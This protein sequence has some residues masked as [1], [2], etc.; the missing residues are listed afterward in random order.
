MS[1]EETRSDEELDR[2]DRLPALQGVIIEGDVRDD[3]V[4]LPYAPLAGSAQERL[5]RARA[6]IVARDSAA[7]A[8]AARLAAELAQARA[9]VA[10]S[11]ERV[12][13]ALANER[14]ARAG[15]QAAR[16]AERAALERTREVERAVAD[17]T[18]QLSSLQREHA[19]SVRQLE[20]ELLTWRAR[21]DAA[22]GDL[23]A[24]RQS[25]AAT[26]GRLAGL[27]EE[28]RAARQE[29]E[30]LRAQALSYQEH[31]R[32]RERR[33]SGEVPAPATDRAAEVAERER[34]QQRTHEL[35][36][37][38]R[39]RTEALDRALVVKRADDALRLEQE[40]RI[41][42][43]EAEMT[44][45]RADLAQREAALA[46]ALV[47]RHAEERR[48]AGFAGAAERVRGE[49]GAEIE[50][51]HA[52]LTQVEPETEALRRELRAK[53]A[54]LTTLADEHRSLRT[55]LD[56]LRA[57]DA[58]FPTAGAASRAEM[59]AG[60]A[61]T[62]AA[63]VPELRRIDGGRNEVYP[64]GRRTR[65]GR[66]PGCELH[67]ESSSVSRHHSLVLCSASEVV[68]EDLN[69]TNGVLVNGRRISRQSLGDG[70]VLTI[71]EAQF[72]FSTRPAEARSAA[73]GTPTPGGTDTGSG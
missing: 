47:A 35:E 72:R 64:L 39:A 13:A 59:A 54:E 69:S 66:A 31:L 6:E 14:A 34:L 42:Q 65:I 22:A 30:G 36:G 16:S 62:D 43:L 63:G 17:R 52:R 18:A 37:A 60:G 40:K 1:S 71:G 56:R 68:I 61:M 12:R 10:D 29:A 51:L 41:R 4:P 57:V 8:R 50:R 73:S 32:T 58:V 11:E 27:E 2:T 33:E 20:A 19:A 21:A 48:S 9:A 28:L 5:A 45:S 49:L 46:E 55:T 70:D 25:A 53:A 15:E 3:A 24:S 26:G 44:R 67:I 7:S 38:L 23:R